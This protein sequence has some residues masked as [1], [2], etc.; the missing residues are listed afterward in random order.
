MFMTILNMDP[1]KTPIFYENVRNKIVLSI[2]NSIRV[3]DKGY[4]RNGK[5]RTA[6]AAG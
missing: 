5:Y 6:G 4:F 3:W 2:T 1:K